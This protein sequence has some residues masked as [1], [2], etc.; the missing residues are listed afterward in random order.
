LFFFSGLFSV[1]KDKIRLTG[2]EGNYISKS[3]IQAMVYGEVDRHILFININNLKDELETYPGIRAVDIQK[4][5]PNGLLVAVTPSKIILQKREGKQYIPIDEKGKYCDAKKTIIKTVPLLETDTKNNQIMSEII[6]IANGVDPKLL[7]KI[8]SF[9]AETTHNIRCSLG[10]FTI[11]WGD[12]NE[13]SVKA[14]ALQTILKNPDMLNGKK[15]IN[16]SSPLRPTLR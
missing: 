14:K 9:T 6:K 3:Q 2:I 15:I 5:W 8:S 11:I 12:S 10:G 13:L 1:K 4:R 16:V 7:E